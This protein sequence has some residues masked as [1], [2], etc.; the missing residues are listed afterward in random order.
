MAHVQQPRA[1]AMPRGLWSDSQLLRDL[2]EGVTSHAIGDSSAALGNKECDRSWSRKDPVSFV[3]VFFQRL[4]R[5]WMNGDMSRLS[6]LRSPY[7]QNTLLKVHILSVQAESFV[8]AHSGRRE[9]AK[10]SRIRVGSE[11]HRRRK[12]FSP[13]KK[14]GNFLV[15]KDVWRLSLIAVAENRFRWNLCPRIH[16]VMPPSEPP[17]HT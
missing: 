8:Y 5:G 14:T 11:F 9:Q 10:K 13:A 6:K 7:R 12:L 15:A 1:A 17:N 2:C 16:C 4:Y 3:G